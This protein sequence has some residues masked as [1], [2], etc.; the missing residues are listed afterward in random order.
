MHIVHV[1]QIATILLKKSK[2]IHLAKAI[3]GRQ[4]GYSTYLRH[5]TRKIKE[6]YNFKEKEVKKDNNANE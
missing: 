2:E 1:Q 5:L 6:I 3:R 4:C